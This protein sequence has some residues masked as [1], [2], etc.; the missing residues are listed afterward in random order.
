MFSAELS[1]VLK[2]DIICIILIIVAV[3]S[4]SS[5]KVVW[6]FVSMKWMKCS[7]QS[8]SFICYL[9]WVLTGNWDMFLSIQGL[10]LV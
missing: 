4:I 7:K 3:D 5:L 9:T 2:Y 10:I 6:L 1:P 8:K